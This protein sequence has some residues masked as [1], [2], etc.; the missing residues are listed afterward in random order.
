[1]LY[2][3][4]SYIPTSA[5][6]RIRSSRLPSS[7]NAHGRQQHKPSHAPHWP[8]ILLAPPSRAPIPHPHHS[9]SGISLLLHPRVALYRQ[10]LL[11]LPGHLRPAARKWISTHSLALVLFRRRVWIRWWGRRWGRKAHGF[12]SGLVLLAYEFCSVVGCDNEVLGGAGGWNRLEVG[13]LWVASWARYLMSRFR[14]GLGWY[15][16][17]ELEKPMI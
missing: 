7:I 1:M 9:R 6:P 13:R 3:K 17:K 10:T 8:P 12:V 11:L 4:G 16:F 15:W 2:R 14:R 5:I